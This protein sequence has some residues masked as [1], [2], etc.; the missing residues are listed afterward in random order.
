MHSLLNLLNSS[1]ISSSHP[2]GKEGPGICH[3]W[4]HTRTKG[5]RMG[6]VDCPFTSEM[7]DFFWKEKKK[8]K[9]KE[10]GKEG[11][12]KEKREKERKRKERKKREEKA[13]ILFPFLVPCEKWEKKFKSSMQYSILKDHLNNTFDFLLYR[14]FFH[15]FFNFYKCECLQILTVTHFASCVLFSSYLTAYNYF[16]PIHIP[17]CP[18]SHTRK[19]KT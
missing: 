4:G 7:H 10:K 18:Y 11:R 19:N 6:L 5:E 13:I 14:I 2:S 1:N 15:Y 17:S 3:V 16:L 12:N 9:R 8:R